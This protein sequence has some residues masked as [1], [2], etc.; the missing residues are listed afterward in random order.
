MF[1]MNFDGAL[2]FESDDVLE[3]VRWDGGMI[4]YFRGFG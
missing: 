3:L 2:R 4:S 1:G